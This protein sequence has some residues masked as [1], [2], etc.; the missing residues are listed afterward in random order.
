MHSCGIMGSISGKKER[1]SHAEGPDHRQQRHEFHQQS[2]HTDRG[3]AIHPAPVGE[4]ACHQVRRQRDGQRGPDAQDS[5]GRDAAQVCGH[6]SDPGARRRAG[7]QRDA[8][9]C[10]RDEFIPQRAADHGRR[11]DGDRADG[12]CG[13]AEQEHCGADQHAGRQGDRAMRQGCAADPC[14][15]EAA[16]CG[17]CGSGAR[18]RHHQCE[19]EAAERAVCGRVHPGNLFDRRGRSGREL[20]H[21]CGHGGGGDC[22]RAEGG[23]ADLSDGH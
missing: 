22:D 10:G 4:D 20:Q 14:D 7:D 23:E 15:E 2:E 13:Q 16:A 21:Q 6:Q 19:H 9:A 8:C 1:A 17:R 11:D 3:A 5:G 12:A 18:G